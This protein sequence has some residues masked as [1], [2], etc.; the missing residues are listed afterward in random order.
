MCS[1]RPQM[2]CN[3]NK[4]M[5]NTQNHM[6]TCWPASGRE[7]LYKAV[8]L[9]WPRCLKILGRISWTDIQIVTKQQ[10]GLI[11][12]PD[13]HLDSHCSWTWCCSRFS[14]GIVSHIG[15]ATPPPPFTCMPRVA[16]LGRGGVVGF[17][18]KA[19]WWI[20]YTC[21]T[22]RRWKTVIKCSY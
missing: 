20:L 11:C 3:K 4:Q 17:K 22:L 21:Q 18:G 16:A 12:W 1:W 14:R 2:S 6:A 9:S 15:P 10:T 5:P 19:S 8:C 7:L 13:R